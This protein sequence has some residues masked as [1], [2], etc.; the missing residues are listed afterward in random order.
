MI[1]AGGVAM[2]VFASVQVG[3]GETVWR[4]PGFDVG[5]VALVL[6]LAFVAWRYFKPSPPPPP[7]GSGRKGIV[8]G[9]NSDIRIT[10]SRFSK[11][12]GTAVESDGLF[13][14]DENEYN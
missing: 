10:R 7:P 6:G 14:G 13:E 8:G 5:V 9:P 12:L 4:S 2:A 11:D 1:P 3:Q